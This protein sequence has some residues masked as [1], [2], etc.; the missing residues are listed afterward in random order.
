[1]YLE[2]LSAFLSRVALLEDAD[3]RVELNR[4]RVCVYVK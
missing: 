3:R 1:M 2:P 4:H